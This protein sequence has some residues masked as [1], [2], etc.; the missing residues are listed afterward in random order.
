[1][2][3]RLSERLAVVACIDPDAYVAGAE[4]S[5]WVD[6]SKF[7]RV[8][9]VVMAGDLGTSATLDAKLQEATDVAGTGAQ[10]ISG[11]AITQ[12]TEAGTDSNKQAII[13]I[14]A[15][16][17]TAGFDF[18]SCEMTVAVATSDCGVIALAGDPRYHPASDNDLASVDEIVA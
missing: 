4:S 10:D 15:D 18:V 7:E 11:K 9:F 8:I 13:E 14:K 1:M 12:L 3:D 6:M 5:D 17:L 16:E 2:T